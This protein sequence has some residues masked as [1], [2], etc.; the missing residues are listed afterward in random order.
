MT[1]WLW[2]ALGVA[3]GWIFCLLTAVS[4]EEYRWHRKKENS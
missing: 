1:W 2:F 4:V 3:C